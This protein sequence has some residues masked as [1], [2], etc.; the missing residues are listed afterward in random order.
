VTYRKPIEVLRDLSDDRA[1]ELSEREYEGAYTFL[2]LDALSE[3][4]VAVPDRLLARPG[5]SPAAA[6]VA[7]SMIAKGPMS[8]EDIGARFRRHWF[9]MRDGCDVSEALEECRRARLVRVH[10]DGRYEVTR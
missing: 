7:A 6:I 9:E 2:R 10:S 3:Q 8:T 1:Y 4:A 5:I